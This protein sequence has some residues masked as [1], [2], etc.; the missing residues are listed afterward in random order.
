MKNV[1]VFL[2]ASDLDEKY[3]KPA[4][5]LGRLLAENGYGFVY[6]GSDKGLMKVMA[7]AVQEAGGSIIGVTMEMLKESRKLDATEMIICTDLSERKKVMSERSDAAIVMVGGIGT[8][9][10]VTELLELKKHGVHN[11]PIIFLNTDNF[12]DGLKILLDKMEKENFLPKRVEDM[13]FFADTPDEV[14]KYLRNRSN[15]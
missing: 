14:I 11:K 5:E 12:Y 7:S 6:G 2:S 9:D 15:L 10:E 3:N 13:V 4:K 1:C 8:L